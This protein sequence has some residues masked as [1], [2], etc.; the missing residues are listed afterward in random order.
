MSRLS[1]VI[2]CLSLTH[3]SRCLLLLP[4][5]DNARVVWPCWTSPFDLIY[6]KSF[7]FTWHSRLSHSESPTESFYPSYFSSRLLCLCRWEKS[8]KQTNKSNDT[9]TVKKEMNERGEQQQRRV[10][11][12]HARPTRREE[13]A[14][15]YP[16]RTGTCSRGWRHSKTRLAALCAS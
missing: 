14:V 7:F 4:R 3:S 15:R 8:D 10:S 9:A 13:V 11:E 16:G 12:C 2:V 5:L 6:Q 1:C